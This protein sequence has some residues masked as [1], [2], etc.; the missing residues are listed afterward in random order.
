MKKSSKKPGG[1]KKTPTK[2]TQSKRRQTTTKLLVLALASR[3]RKAGTKRPNT[4]RPPVEPIARIKGNAIPGR[5]DALYCS[6]IGDMADKAV[7]DME[8]AIIQDD[9]AALQKAIEDFQGAWD[10]GHGR[11]CYFTYVF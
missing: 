8:Q 5:G 11:G 10:T 4:T 7:D 1:T 9:D 2:R 3:M 6:V